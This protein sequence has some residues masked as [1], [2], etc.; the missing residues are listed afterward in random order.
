MGNEKIIKD[1]KF[2]F[3]KNDYFKIGIREER[4]RNDIILVNYKEGINLC[5]MYMNNTHAYVEFPY[6]KAMLDEIRQKTWTLDNIGRG[7][8]IFVKCQKDRKSLNE[9]LKWY[10]FNHQGYEYKVYDTRY[11]NI[12][13]E[14]YDRKRKL[15]IRKHPL[16]NSSYAV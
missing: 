11:D 10:D 16:S 14:E 2:L 1:F 4:L 3:L 15:Y 13:K 9:I 6:N 7:T 12:S 5:R 8:G